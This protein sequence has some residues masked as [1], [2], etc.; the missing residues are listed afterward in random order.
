MAKSIIEDQ[1]FGPEDGLE[2]ISKGSM[3]EYCNFRNCDFSSV[4]FSDCRFVN[5]NFYECNISNVKI[6]G[7]GFQDCIFHECK[8][9]GFAVNAANPLGLKMRFEGCNLSHAVFFATN[10]K[11]FSF[12]DCK[13]NGA[14]FTDADCTSVNFALCDFTNAVFDNTKLLT[15]DLRTCINYSIDPRKN[16]VKGAYFDM[17]HVIGLL[18]AFQIKI[19]L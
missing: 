4:D 11:A 17:P 10:I 1:E 7:V 15:A 18:Q 8:M 5:C 12:K 13:L 14:D 2:A 6:A 19:K 3:Y 9:L 16:N